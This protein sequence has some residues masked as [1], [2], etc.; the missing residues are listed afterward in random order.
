[1]PDIDIVSRLAG[2][3][4]GLLVGDALGVPYEFRPP[5][6]IE[7]VELH[8]NGSHD[9]LAGTWKQGAN[10][11][12]LV[13]QRTAAATTVSRPQEPKKPYPYAEEEVI[14]E[15]KTAGLKLAGTLTLPDIATKEPTGGT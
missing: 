11:L 14:V 5:G 4:L 6:S 1:M 10:A 9:Q 2:G 12:P 13:F 8:G 15:N 7:T 3:M